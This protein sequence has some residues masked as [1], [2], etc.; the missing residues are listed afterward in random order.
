MMTYFDAYFRKKAVYTLSDVAL[1]QNY[2]LHCGDV[3]IVVQGLNYIVDLR[4]SNGKHTC[5]RRCLLL[6]S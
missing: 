5:L 6:L 1:D 4:H 2:K 3:E